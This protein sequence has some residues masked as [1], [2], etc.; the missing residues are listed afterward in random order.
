MLQRILRCVALLLGALAFG[1]AVGAAAP[2]RIIAV[3]DLHG[4]YQA[5]TDIARAAGLIDPGGKWIG[6]NTYLVQL[7]DVT[8]REPDSL[9]IIRSL[10]RLQKEAPRSGGK[11][12]VVLGN[13][14]YTTPG[15]LAAFVDSRSEQRRD[16]AFNLLRDKI[17]AAYRAR[18]PKM[19]A[20]AIKAAW[21]K[22]TPL[23]LLEHNAAW[24]PDGEL[25]R[26]ARGN[27]AILRIDGT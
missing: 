4:D 10:Q 15:E 21:Y 22:A 14:R 1:T 17:E 13:L 16:Q 26:W 8:D 2:Q 24:R 9:K 7:G 5:W 12:T 11:V 23:G 19:P 3:G 25:G 6:G 27:P 18:D 20:A